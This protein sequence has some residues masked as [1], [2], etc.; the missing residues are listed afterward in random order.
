MQNSTNEVARSDERP[1]YLN[2][3]LEAS[4]LNDPMMIHLNCPLLNDYKP[5]NAIDGWCFG[6]K[7][8]PDILFCND[9]SDFPLSSSRL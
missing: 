9:L 2:W 1:K 6:F 4:T 7:K 8:I 5:E 3:R